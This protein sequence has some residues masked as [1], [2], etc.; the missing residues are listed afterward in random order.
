[1]TGLRYRIGEKKIKRKLGNSYACVTFSI[2]PFQS[3]KEIV[4]KVK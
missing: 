3:S 4:G 2:S 1:M